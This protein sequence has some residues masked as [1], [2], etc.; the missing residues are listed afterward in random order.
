MK[1]PG[2]LPIN[3]IYKQFSQLSQ[4]QLDALS[5]SVSI[6]PQNVVS[7]DTKK[8]INQRNRKTFSVRLKKWVEPYDIGGINYSLFYTEV[9]HNYKKGDKVFIE[10]GNYDSD[11][12]V[13]LNRYGRGVDGYK[14]LFVDRCKLV[15][16]IKYTG[17]D[18]TNEEDIDNFTK[19][20]VAKSQYELDY[21]LQTLSMRDDNNTIGNKFDIGYNNFLYIDGSFRINNVYNLIGFLLEDGSTPSDSVAGFYVRDGMRMTEITTDVMSNTFTAWL[22]PANNTS[23]GFYNNGKLKIMNNYFTTGGIKFKNTRYYHFDINW[24][25]D[26]SYLPVIVTEQHFRAGNFNG[27][28]NQGLFGRYEEGLV[29]NRPNVKWNLGTVLNTKWEN[30]VI[31]STIFHKDSHFTVFDRDGLPQIR[32]NSENNGNNGYNYVFDTDFVGGDVIKGNIFNLAVLYGTNSVTSTL[33]NYVTNQSTTYSVNLTGGVYYDSDIKF[34]N[35]ENSTLINSHILNSKMTNS[36]SVNSEIESSVFLDSSYLSDKIVKIQ[37]YEE[38]NI[39]WYDKT[40]NLDY[41][42]YK[43]YVTEDNFRRLNDFQNFYFQD[44]K[45]D[46]PSTELLH[47]FDD[48]FSVGHYEQ[49]YDGPNAKKSRKVFVQLS[50]KAENRNSPG[51]ISGTQTAPEANFS[52]TLPSLDVFIHEGDDFNY[53]TASYY[54]RDFIANILDI[55]KGYI[56]E[57]DFVSGLF[58]DSTWVSGNHIDYNQEYSFYQSSTVMIPLIYSDVP[59]YSTASLTSASQEISIDVPSERRPNI[60]GTTSDVSQIA[61]VNGLYYDTSLSVGANMVKMP[62]TYKV[63]SMG[64]VSGG[65]EIV[66]QDISTQSIISDLPDFNTSPSYFKTPWAENKWNYIHPVKFENSTIKSGIFRRAYFEGCT[67]ENEILDYTDKD[68]NNLENKR[69]LLISDV[70]LDDNNNK[71]NNGFFQYSHRIS[72]SDKWNSGIFH[73]GVWGGKTFTYSFGATSSLFYTKKQ[74]DFNGGVFRKSKWHWGDFNG[75]SFYK[76]GSNQIGNWNFF[77]G[78]QSMY[79]N[80]NAEGANWWFQGNFNGGDFEK[81]NFFRGN[82]NNGNFYDSNFTVGQINGGNFGRKNIP[83]ERTRVFTATVSYTNVVNAEFR[84]SSPIYGA[85]PYQPFSIYWEDGVFNDGV[86][87]NIATA[88]YEYDSI[89]KDGTFNGGEFTDFALWENGTFNGGKF[90][91][92]RGYNDADPQTPFDMQSATASSYTWLDG[93]FNG[94]EFGNGSTGS[95]SLWMKGEFNGGLFKGRYWN[96]GVFTRGKFEGHTSTASGYSTDLGKVDDT[97]LINHNKFIRAFNYDY[98]GYWNNGFVSE[99][100]DKFIKNEKLYTKLERESTKKKKRKEVEFKNVYWANGTFSHTDAT[101]INSI[102]RDGTFENGLFYKSSF[103]PYHNYMTPIFAVT[104]STADDWSVTSTVNP[105]SEGYYRYTGN[106][107]PSG[108]IQ[109]L[110]SL[111][112]GEQYTL[113]IEVVGNT[114]SSDVYINSGADL[115]I[116]AGQTGVLTVPFVTTSDNFDMFFIGSGSL[117]FTKMIVYPGTQSGFNIDDSCVWNN[118]T[119]DESDFFYSNWKQGRFKATSPKSLNHQGNAYGM[120]WEDGICDYMNAYNVFWCDGTWRNGNWNG[121]PFQAIISSTYSSQTS[122]YPGF[123]EDIM[124]N[125]SDFGLQNGWE[126]YEFVHMNDTF[127]ASFTDI[128]ADPIL[129]L[130]FAAG[131]SVTQSNSYWS[132]GVSLWAALQGYDPFSIYTDTSNQRVFAWNPPDGI[133]VFREPTFYTISIDYFVFN[134]NTAT[135]SVGV[136]EIGVGDSSLNGGFVDTISDTADVLISGI[137]LFLDGHYGVCKTV[138]YTFTSTAEV[139]GESAGLYIKRL[140]TSDSGTQIHILRIDIEQVQASYDPLTN[141]Q[142]WAPPAWTST[143]GATISLP[144]TITYNIGNLNSRYGNGTF[145]A[146]VWENGVWN[147]GWRSDHTTIWAKDLS[148]FVGS[149]QFAYRN[150]SWNWTIKLDVITGT[151]SPGDISDYEVGDKVSVGNIVTIDI[152]ENRRLVRGHMIITDID[153]D[154]I[155]LTFD[156]NFPIRKVER[157]SEEHIIHISK[158]LWLNGVFLNGHFLNGVWNNGLIQGYTYITNMGRTQWIDGKYKGGRFRGL[159]DYYGYDAASFSYHTALI[160]KFEFS[161]ENVSGVPFKFKFNSWVDVNYFRESGVNINRVNEVFNQTPLSFTTSYIENNHYGFPTKDVL[162][163]VSTIRN[164]YD[165]NTR[166]YKLGWKFK[167]YQEW[168]PQQS[169]EVQFNS[170]NEYSWQNSGSSGT[171]EIIGIDNGS[172]Y[173]LTN[174]EQYGWTFG[175]GSTDTFGDAENSIINNY[176]TLPIELQNKLIFSG[177]KLGPSIL[178]QNLENYTL[179]YIDNTEIDIERLRYSFVEITGENL[180]PVSIGSELNPIVFFNNYPAS[181]S[182]A[183]K[184]FYYGNTQS[185]VTIPVNQFATSS[186]VNQR[187]YFYNKKGLEMTLLGGSDANNGSYSMAFE[188]IRLVETDMIPFL[189]YTGDCLSISEGVTDPEDITLAQWNEEGLTITFRTNATRDAG[190]DYFEDEQ[191]NIGPGVVDRSRDQE[192]G[193]Y[194]RVYYY[195]C[196]GGSCVLNFIQYG[197]WDDWSSMTSEGPPIEA[198][199]A[200]F[201]LILAGGHIINGQEVYPAYAYTLLYPEVISTPGGGYAHYEPSEAI[202]WGLGACEAGCEEDPCSGAFD[203]VVIGSISGLGQPGDELSIAAGYNLNGFTDILT[204]PPYTSVWTLPDGSTQTVTLPNPTITTTMAGL[205]TL[206]ITHIDGCEWT[207]SQDIAD[208]VGCDLQVQLVQVGD[209]IHVSVTYNGDVVAEVTSGGADNLSTLVW[210]RFDGTGFLNPVFGPFSAPLLDEYLS[211]P[212]S[213]WP[214]GSQY[215]IGFDE[216]YRVTVSIGD[217]S[218]SAM[219]YIGEEQNPD[220]STGLV[221]KLFMNFAGYTQ[222]YIN[223]SGYGNPPEIHDNPIDPISGEPYFLPYY[224][225]TDWSYTLQVIWDPTSSKWVFRHLPFTHPVD[226][227]SSLSVLTSGANGNRIIAHG[228]SNILEMQSL[229][230]STNWTLQTGGV[231]WNGTIDSDTLVGQDRD[232]VLQVIKT[233][234]GNW[235]YAPLN[236]TFDVLSDYYDVQLLPLLLTQYTTS[237]VGYIGFRKRNLANDNRLQHPPNPPSQWYNSNYS[238]L[239]IGNDFFRIMWLEEANNFVTGLNWDIQAPFVPD[240]LGG[241]IYPAPDVEDASNYDLVREVGDWEDLIGPVL[242][243]YPGA[244]SNLHNEPI[245]TLPNSI[246]PDPTEIDSTIF[247]NSSDI[248]CFDYIN[249]D[250]QIPNSAIA[251]DIEYDDANFDYISSVDISINDNI[252][253]V[254][255][256]GNPSDPSPPISLPFDPDYN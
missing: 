229:L 149:K 179:D 200:L 40:S 20:Y 110:N 56:I 197:T 64:T 186:V 79:N 95:N 45:I 2:K 146:G 99:N 18:P 199:L 213:S 76:N 19:I 106:P 182:V 25:E 10:G 148:T 77:F 223:D 203:I 24:K 101:I 220:Y 174:L 255:V 123:N 100:K 250:I 211:Y 3:T 128:L 135:S 173:G 193:G 180:N 155:T 216:T 125:I 241:I 81:S 247:Y 116:P 70:I 202:P 243:A 38:S 144:T 11:D 34:A 72:G 195:V 233:E 181:Y 36:K 26:K 30:G 74:A 134:P 133:S 191:Y 16:D 109:Q 139:I 185:S 115:A 248:I 28:F 119:S 41:K 82:F 227:S 177:G 15:L 92:D 23:S 7:I 141:N 167:E 103:N 242:V 222:S 8:I 80:V 214:P 88:S 93:K 1:L 212:G 154:S 98:Y 152:N 253:N 183:A 94:G 13:L 17:E 52:N 62:D 132:T 96:D 12:Y 37:S 153:T 140:N 29:F 35:V 160:Q 31:D 256:T 124:N 54:P 42:M 219:L 131:G 230:P 237:P 198:G 221:T 165:L 169:Q 63:M 158:C 32:A 120:I 178:G 151:Q 156:I 204:D 157:D 163:S 84:A 231:S 112:T 168:I 75:G 71:I 166:K 49:T 226:P 58:K 60:I 107:F 142:L 130:G 108:S 145:K 249:H 171:Q 87:G 176:G 215:P 85:P 6:S 245:N 190:Q 69:E 194:Y 201:N 68:L 138:E 161:D 9:N 39:V 129:N 86:F 113:Q 90:I 67:F 89:W 206:T 122:V 150:D 78:T 27:T 187:E 208:I 102:W 207:S 252:S 91:S 172:G 50:T 234:P 136:F 104:S 232:L 47:F 235:A 159:E 143:H 196:N 170:I 236:V 251:P 43:F 53:A 225:N 218:E 127:S 4:E 44:L 61:F 210:E 217:C 51:I 162:E 126:D 97:I 33:E 55:T 239:M 238:Q 121:S 175:Y 105:T 117:I 240:L 21:Y 254:I 147:E 209:E 228:S 73:K 65:R 66:L 14:V 205:Y 224:E 83:Y 137:I 59:R 164:G 184:T 5:N 57:S 22:N 118:G 244:W 48:K 189:N 192:G 46:I 246:E 114:M 111:Q 188:K